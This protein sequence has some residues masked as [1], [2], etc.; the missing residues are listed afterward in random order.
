MRDWIELD[1]FVVDCIIGVLEREQ[2]VPQPVEVTVRLGLDHDAVAGGDLSKGL[3]YA[4]VQAQ[5]VSFLQF[6]QWRLLESVAVGLA[7]LL[8]APPSPAEARAQVSAVS[9]K[10][11]KPTILDGAV[12][13]IGLERDAAWC[14]LRTRLVPPKA[15]L[16]TLVETPRAGAYRVHLEPGTKWPVPPG[17][18]LH[19]LAGRLNGVGSALQPGQ[20][21][22]RGA[23]HEVANTGADLASLLVLTVPPIA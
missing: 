1:D 2:R 18:A 4:G 19:V 10:L 6:G 22:A 3:D 12:P 20:R 8:L 13:A 21:V 5:V 15:W 23:L 11:R 9:I 7:R 16:D 14:D 17:A